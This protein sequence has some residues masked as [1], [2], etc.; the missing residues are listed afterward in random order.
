[1]AED[2]DHQK[3]SRARAKVWLERDIEAAYFEVLDVL[4]D[5]T[6]Q[7]MGRARR[8]VL[9]EAAFILG[10]EFKSP[11]GSEI[12]RLLKLHSYKAAA[13]KMFPES[14]RGRHQNLR[15][16]MAHSQEEPKPTKWRQILWGLLAG[17]TILVFNYYDY[18]YI[19]QEF[20]AD[21]QAK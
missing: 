18:L 19:I 5:N 15:F 21:L 12:F 3:I 8:E 9:V 10:A 17:L 7:F 4:D 14:F 6:L 13:L 20:W 2:N 11:E 1:M 16:I